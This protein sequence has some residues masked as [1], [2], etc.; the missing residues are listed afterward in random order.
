MSKVRLLVGTRKGAF[1]LMSDGKRDNWEVSG[2]HFAG[3]EIYHVKGSPA[4][5]SRLYAS[6]SSGWFG[7]VIQRSDDGGTTWHQ[8]GTPAGEPAA[9]GPPK[10]ESN[11]FAYDT[12][13]A[14]GKALTTHQ[15]YDGTQHPWEFKRVWHLEPSLTE[16]ETVY[17]GVEDAAL[18]RST[19][20]GKNWQELPGLRGHG[21]GPK[22]QPGAG[23]MCLHTIILDPSNPERIFIAI[24]A[25][26]AFRT[27]DA[28][29]T[30]KPINRGLYSKYIPNPT[31]EIGH[32]VHH[33]A[34]N[35]SRPGVL[36][37]QKH[38]DVMRSDDAGDSWRKISGNLPTDFGFVIDVHAHE[39]ETIYVVPIKS[40]SEHYV[41]EG[42]LRVYRSRSG[43]N[44]WEPLTKGLPQSNCYVN[45]L[46]DAM[47]V[48]SLDKCGVYFG[49]TGG[50]VYASADAGDSWAPI[51]R[52]LPA[53]LS[54]EVQTLE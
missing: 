16:P 29:Q 9:P 20:G 35:S 41:H 10:S 28:G 52:D 33:I 47:A 46:R 3:W 7:Q 11:K 31:A 12:S 2:P 22:W 21:T 8:P 49:T 38:W 5:P 14:A 54:V 4:D 24:S 53:V 17:A 48:D 27:D 45:V 26:G 50:Q 1:V 23:G 43:G 13:S 37:M 32:C 18:F 39:P 6:Q 19:D 15:W 34:M 30:W 36:F 51:V 25:A 40:D 44:E 42:K